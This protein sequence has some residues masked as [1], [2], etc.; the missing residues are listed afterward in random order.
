MNKRAIVTENDKKKN[1]H[2]PDQVFRKAGVN[3]ME[4]LYTDHLRDRSQW[5]PTSSPGR[6]SRPTSK[7]REKR[8]GGEVEWS[9]K[10][11]LRVG[12]YARYSKCR[13]SFIVCF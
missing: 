8:P 11:T 2:F 6:L 3:T 12:E 1:T 9:L 7:A 13:I 4:L 10:N 5:S